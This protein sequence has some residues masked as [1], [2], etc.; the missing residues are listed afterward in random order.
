MRSTTSIVAILALVGS[1]GTSLIAAPV[2]K[3]HTSTAD[4][5]AELIG[6]NHLSKEMQ[7]FRD[8]LKSDPVAKCF[9]AGVGGSV[10]TGFHH[11]WKD[12]GLTIAFDDTGVT[13]SAVLHVSPK[14]KFK[15]FAEALPHG[16][17]AGDTPADIRKKLGDPD[18]EESNS[19]VRSPKVGAWWDYPKHGLLIRF[20]HSS[21]DDREIQIESIE[22]RGV[23]VPNEKR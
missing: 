6:K 20:T 17:K 2:P 4:R 22:V 21:V 3:N 12:L 5:L 11:V 9:V 1:L 8:T 15:P 19:N 18:P 13:E 10:E 14:D 23:K 7:E 16:L